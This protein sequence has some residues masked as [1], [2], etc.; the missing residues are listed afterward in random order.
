MYCLKSRGLL[1]LGVMIF[2]GPLVAGCQKAGEQHPDLIV[3]HEITP[4]PPRVGQATITLR[5][6]DAGG[7][8]R[9]GAQVSLEGNM[10]HAGMRPVFG[11]AREIE[12]GRYQAP[13]EFTMGG[14]WI[15]LINITMPDGRKHQ[16]RVEVKAVQSG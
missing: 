4:Q 1:I 12:P 13:I 16:R 7:V 2:A 8:P 14:D 11:E 9:N 6:S 3:E 10:S 5:L 15:I